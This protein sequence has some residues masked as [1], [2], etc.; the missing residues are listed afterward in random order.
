MNE[1]IKN[2]IGRR[3]CR[4]YDVSR[5]INDEDIELILEA[6]KFAA[7]GGNRQ[8]WH[9]TVLQNKKIMDDITAINREAMLN[10]GVEG[11]IQIA[12]SP[13]FD[14]WRGAPVAIL[15]SGEDSVQGAGS[16]VDCANATQNLCVAAYSLGIGSCYIASYTMALLKPENKAILDELQIPAGYTPLFAVTLGYCAEA[17]TPRHPR[18]EG[19]VTYLR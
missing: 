10:S 19:I 13:D 11:M 16:G 2:L 4:S 17:D 1:T 12:K 3:S 7:T 6:G 18:R 8:P 14:S 15:V 5:P 9:F